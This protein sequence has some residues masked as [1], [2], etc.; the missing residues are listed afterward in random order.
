MNAWILRNFRHARVHGSKLRGMRSTKAR[1]RI[2]HAGAIPHIFHDDLSEFGIVNF[3]VAVV[4]DA[5]DDALNVLWGD[6]F[7]HTPVRM[8]GSR[9]R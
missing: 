7:A 9:G 8:G 1:S 2:L 5:G 3:S 6:L 4:V